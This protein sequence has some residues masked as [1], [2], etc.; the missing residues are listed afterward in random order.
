MKNSLLL[1]LICFS[2]FTLFACSEQEDDV[3]MPEVTTNSVRTE[4]EQIIAEENIDELWATSVEVCSNISFF[5]GT[6]DYEFLEFFI[7]IQDRYYQYDRLVN[8][9]I[10]G[11]QMLLC[12]N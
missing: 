9:E 3:M 1:T 8:F 6:E 4:M 7:R 11:N 2:L 12:F 5:A 10:E